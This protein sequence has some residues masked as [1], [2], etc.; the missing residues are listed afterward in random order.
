MPASKQDERHFPFSKLEHLLPLNDEA[1]RLVVLC[2]REHTKNQKEPCWN[3]EQIPVVIHGEIVKPNRAIL[4]KIYRK[5]VSLQWFWVWHWLTIKSDLRAS[6]ALYKSQ[7]EN[8]S[9][10]NV[11]EKL[12]HTVAE[13]TTDV[14]EQIFGQ[15]SFTSGQEV[16]QLAQKDDL[17]VTEQNSAGEARAKSHFVVVREEKRWS[18]GIK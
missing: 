9:Y 1:Q 4:H 18:D 12:K 10:A 13:A 16:F 14:D 15:F 11:H 7:I 3:S 17:H 8:V 2:Y 5:T 6:E